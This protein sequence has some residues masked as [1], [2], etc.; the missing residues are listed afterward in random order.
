MNTGSL[1]T[2]HHVRH[3]QMNNKPFLGSA[4]KRDQNS[5]CLLP[6]V[7]TFLI[8]FL[9]VSSVSSCLRSVAATRV[10]RRPNQRPR[11]TLSIFTCCEKEDGVCS[12]FPNGGTEEQHQVLDTSEDCGVDTAA[13]TEGLLVQTSDSA[14]QRSSPAVLQSFLELFSGAVKKRE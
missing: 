14:P 9:D 12:T 11:F 8:V 13:L 1:R 10:K 6:C 7:D 4:T 5:T 3:H 2:I